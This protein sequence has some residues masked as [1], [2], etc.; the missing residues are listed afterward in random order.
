MHCFRIAHLAD[1]DNVRR[2]PQS[3]SKRRRE[4]GS[5]G[6]N[7]NLFNQTLNVLVFLL[8]GVFDHDDMAAFGSVDLIQ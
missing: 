7:L 2:L 3:S 5:V 1:N 8:N 6:P 4:I